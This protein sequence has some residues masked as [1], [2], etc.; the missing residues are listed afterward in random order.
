MEEMDLMIC[1][2]KRGSH[3]DMDMIKWLGFPGLVSW[4]TGDLGGV[5]GVPGKMEPHIGVGVGLNCHDP[6]ETAL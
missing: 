6:G 1:A 5:W 4:G 3:G 2:D